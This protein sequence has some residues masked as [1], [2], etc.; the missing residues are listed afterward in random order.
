[1]AGI[2]KYRHV[3]PNVSSL[4]N[5]A[6]VAAVVLTQPH[7]LALESPSFQANAQ[8]EMCKKRKPFLMMD[9]T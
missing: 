8:W 9:R 7:V 5:T 2:F 6:L 4:H 3:F 1:M